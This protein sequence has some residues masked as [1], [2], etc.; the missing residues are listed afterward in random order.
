[1]VV[2]PADQLISQ[3]GLFYE[4]LEAA[5]LLAQQ[6]YLV[7]FGITPNSPESGGYIKQGEL[8]ASHPDT[9]GVYQVERFVEKPDTV[10]ARQYLA[11]GGYLWNSGIFFWQA[12]VLLRAVEKWQPQLNQKLAQ[13]RL[14]EGG[15]PLELPKAI[16]CI[17]TGPTGVSKTYLASALARQSCRQGFRSAYYHF[18][19]LITKLRLAKADGSYPALVANLAKRH[20]LVIDDWLRDPLTPEQSRLILDLLDDRYRC[21]PPC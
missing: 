9:R 10:T 17:I 5:W 16:T 15:R 12:A 21:P 7:T 14:D 1:M 18:P 3:P 8:L 6:E 11:D 4:A 19:E 13:M 20:L 2:L